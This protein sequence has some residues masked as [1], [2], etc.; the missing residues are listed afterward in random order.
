MVGTVIQA[1]KDVFGQD[2]TPRVFFAPG[3][4]NLIG[5]HT[6]YNGGHVLPCALKRG[7]YA[8]AVKRQDNIIRLYSCN[9]KNLGITEIS[10][11]TMDLVAQSHW[12]D[13]P[14]GML[15]IFRN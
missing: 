11:Q 2:M 15:Q 4:V 1:F 7:T 14:L 5:E 13:Y 3:R 6:D 12:T 10:I 8:A 9:F